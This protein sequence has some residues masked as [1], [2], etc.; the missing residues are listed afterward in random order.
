MASVD[1]RQ[2]GEPVGALS[3][4]WCERQGQW[5]QHRWQ[6]WPGITSVLGKPKSLWDVDIT[7]ASFA[8]AIVVN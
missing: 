2:R 8:G 4:M 5:R 3:Q 6:M 1:G 7:F